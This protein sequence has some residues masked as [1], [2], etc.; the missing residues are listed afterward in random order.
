MN[1]LST[2]VFHLNDFLHSFQF[3]PMF[4]FAFA[5]ALPWLLGAAGIGT[6]AYGISSANKTNKAN[7]Q[8]QQASQA[9]YEARLKAAQEGFA[10][11]QEQ[12]NQIRSERPDLTWQGYVGELITSLNDPNLTKAYAEAKQSDFQVLEA[13]ASK[14]TSDNVENFQ[15]AFDKASNGQGKEIID[16]RNDLVLNDDTQARVARAYELRAPQISAV[17]YDENGD[18][19]QGQRADKQVFQTAYE[20]V[21]DTNRERLQNISQ[22]ER[23]RTATAISQQQRATDF[24]P[25]YDRTGFAATAFDKNRTERIDFQKLDE[26]QAF[27]LMKTFASA[28]MGITPT[29]PAYQGNSLAG[30]LVGSGITAAASGFASAYNGNKT[31]FVSGGRQSVVHGLGDRPNIYS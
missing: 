28:S 9:D 4:G 26:M 2:I 15:S 1:I 14:A 27:E 22:L 31:P 29:Q 25:F 16:S 6:A 30:S 7:E 11:M 18:V 10:Q 19:V 13:L 17:K 3:Y 5:A 12:Y 23:D 21:V 24:M 20:T 8:A